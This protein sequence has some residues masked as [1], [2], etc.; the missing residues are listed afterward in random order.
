[1]DAGSILGDD[2]QPGVGPWRT[3]GRGDAP[4]EGV[5]N[6][7]QRCHTGEHSPYHL[8]DGAG[9][10]V[11]PVSGLHKEDRRI[12]GERVLKER[13]P[14]CKG[15]PGLKPWLACHSAVLAPLLRVPPLRWQAAPKDW[16][17]SAVPAYLAEVGIGGRVAKTTR[18]ETVYHRGGAIKVTTAM[19][20][21][22][23][24]KAWASEL[25]VCRQRPGT[26]PS[27]TRLYCLLVTLPGVQA[28]ANAHL[29]T[30]LWDDQHHMSLGQLQSGEGGG[31][32][33]HRLA[34]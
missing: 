20:D 9:S 21:T 8:R 24:A 5:P 10:R 11:P 7:V 28:Q 19:K 27:D 17:P 2:P 3:A 12:K 33:H 29:H 14:A 26:L 4:R 15:I 1:M 34:A 31:G 30:Q 32:G 18:K 13:A 25:R 23:Q 6:P 22:M 16:I